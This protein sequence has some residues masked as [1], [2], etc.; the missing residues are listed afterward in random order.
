MEV[1]YDFQVGRATSP[2]IVFANL[3]L[4]FELQRNDPRYVGLN[5][6]QPEDNAIAL[7]DYTLQMRMIPA[8]GLS[9]R[10]RDAPRRRDRL[11]PRACP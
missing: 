6:V 3:L 9:E 8:H 5:L 10:P 1:R 7:R 2:E 11:R 4:G